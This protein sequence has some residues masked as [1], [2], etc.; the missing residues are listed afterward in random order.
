[1]SYHEI[2]SMKKANAVQSVRKIKAW[3]KLLFEETPSGD[4]QQAQKIRARESDRQ[5]I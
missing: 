4:S 5:I 3:L 2:Y 1:M